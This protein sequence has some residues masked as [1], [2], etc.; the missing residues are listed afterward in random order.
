MKTTICHARKLG[1]CQCEASKPKC[2]CPKCLKLHWG[3][4]PQGREVK[5]VKTRG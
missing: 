4:C 3:K 2:V 1:K 5:D